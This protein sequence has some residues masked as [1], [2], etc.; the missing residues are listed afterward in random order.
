MLCMCAVGGGVLGMAWDVRSEQGAWSVEDD[1]VI[2]E[3]GWMCGY[4]VVLDVVC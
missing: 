4:S 3:W 2:L 1:G